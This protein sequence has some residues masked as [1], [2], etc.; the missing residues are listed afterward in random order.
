MLTSLGITASFI[1]LVRKWE[2]GFD[3]GM[4]LVYIFSIV[5]ASMADFSTFDFSG[6]IYLLLYFIFTIFTSFL[7]QALLSKM[8]RI[9]ADTM[10]IS[11]VAL[12]NSPPFVP[13]VAAALKNR[14]VIITGL[15]VGIVGYAIGNYLGL[16]I[17]QL[18]KSLSL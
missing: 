10:V 18:L 14:D 12:I 4:Y 7:V 6:G 17:Y 2:H 11:S 13:V 8:F 1:P 3:A 15:G 5:V 9:D 16:L